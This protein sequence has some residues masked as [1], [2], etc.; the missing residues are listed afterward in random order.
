MRAPL[1]LLIAASLCAAV[2]GCVINPVP[3]PGDE[4]GG[5]AFRDNKNAAGTA[6][7]ATAAAM[8]AASAPDAGMPPGA[9][10]AVDLAQ[11]TTSDT[12]AATDA[13][14]PDG[15]GED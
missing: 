13:P 11:S 15:Q 1:R 14:D 12:A 5:A 8:D 4:S 7:D 6:S 9:P 3:T 10:D 2:S